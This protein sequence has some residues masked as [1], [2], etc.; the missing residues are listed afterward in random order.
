MT[1]TNEVFL[2]VS[3]FQFDRGNSTESSGGQNRCSASGSYLENPELVDK[4]SR[5]DMQQ[6]LS[7][8]QTK[9]NLY[10]P[11]NREREYPLIRLNLGV[12]SISGENS[13]TGGFKREQGILSCNPGETVLNKSR[14]LTFL[15]G[16]NFAGQKELIPFN[17]L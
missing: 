7:G 2:Y 3:S 16:L 13:K 10:L 4:S 6:M 12:F 17:P 14:T 11:H 15:S 8:S 1:W 9:Q 5:T